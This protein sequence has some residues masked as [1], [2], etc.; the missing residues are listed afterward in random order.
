M[1][2]TWSGDMRIIEMGLQES[3]HKPYSVIAKCTATAPL[4]LQSQQGQYMVD[5]EASR[6]QIALKTEYN[7]V[8]KFFLT[9]DIQARFE[10]KTQHHARIQNERWRIACSYQKKKF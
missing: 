7:M 1:E 6:K 2:E 5:R 9:R 8:E 3:H 10:W 4:K